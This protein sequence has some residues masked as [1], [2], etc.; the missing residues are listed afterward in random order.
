MKLFL[1]QGVEILHKKK[2]MFSFTISKSADNNTPSAYFYKYMS[3][4]TTNIFNRVLQITYS[5]WCYSCYLNL[6]KIPGISWRKY[7][8]NFLE[9]YNHLSN[10]TFTNHKQL[11][12]KTEWK[13]V[14]QYIYVDHRSFVRCTSMLYRH[15]FASNTVLILFQMIFSFEYCLRLLI[16]PFQT[17]TL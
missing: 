3:L 16:H 11:I 4:I 10:W 13:S 7:E 17:S 12:S 14:V 6:H 2:E 5:S 8:I 15:K 1:S 9:V